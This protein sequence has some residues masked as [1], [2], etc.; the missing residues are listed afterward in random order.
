MN[1]K[2]SIIFGLSTGI[3]L[4]KSI[5]KKTHIQLGTVTKSVFADGET[6]I[7]SDVSVRNKDIFVI[8]STCKKDN[9]SVNDNIFELLI[10]IDSL[11][12]ANA[13]NINVVIPYYGYS[14]QDRKCSQREPISAKLVANL[15][16][17]AGCS[18]LTV[19]DLHSPQ[20]QGFFDIPVDDVPPDPLIVECIRKEF[21]D[22]LKD[23]V[24]VAPDQGAAK[25]C[26]RI[27]KDLQVPVAIIDKDRIGNNDVAL[28]GFIGD[29]KNKTAILID[30]I[31]DT[32]GTI[33]KGAELIKNKG[34]ANEVYIAASHGLF[35]GDANVKLNNS[36]IKGVFVL[37]SIPTMESKKINNLKI[38]D[39]SSFIS[40][41]IL[42]W[43]KERSV[44]NVI[45]NYLI[46]KGKNV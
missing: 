30:D 46:S 23:I 6:L 28:F 2:N 32:A 36:C 45:Q 18:R 19:L 37:N 22:K 16:E 26:V 10:F 13:K 42:A 40:D 14:R 41:V 9:S 29:V 27:A 15:L 7:K 5:S 31:I 8:Q 24:I 25:K 39:T 21:K 3:N 4:A 11:K 17:G 44:G 20:I 12:R 43:I 34:K 38:L 33:V 1:I 35:N